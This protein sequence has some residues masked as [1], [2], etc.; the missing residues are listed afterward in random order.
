IIDDEEAKKLIITRMTNAFNTLYDYHKRKLEDQDLRTAA[1][2][3]AVD[4][5]VSSMKARGLL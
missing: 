5:V 3:L 4:R 2:A 1:M